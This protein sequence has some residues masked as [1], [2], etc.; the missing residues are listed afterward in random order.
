MEGWDA[1]RASAWHDHLTT[2]P[3]L[4]AFLGLVLLMGV[5]WCPRYHLHWSTMEMIHHP[6]FSAIMPRNRYSLLRPFLHLSDNTA[7][8]QNNRLHKLESFLS[9]LTPTF[10]Y[11]YFPKKMI[12]PDGSMIKFKGCLGI[13][14]YMPK[15]PIKWG[16]KAWALCE[17]DS[18][19]TWNWEVYTGH[20]EA[21]QVVNAGDHDGPNSHPP[22]SSI[23]ARGKVV[24]SLVEGLEGKGYWLFCDN[25]YTPALFQ[26][27]TENG[28]GYCGTAR[29]LAKGL[30]TGANPKVH[31]M[32]KG[33]CPKYYKKKGQMRVVCMDQKN[34]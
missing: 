10:H 7:P 15:K 1:D 11:L 2:V 24:L 22:E 30:P 6:F 14:Q 21:L 26:K 3:K 5:V 19:Y 8:N 9:L 20:E 32:K 25:F 31:K 4:K 18:G 34:G 23:C 16:I 12:S 17:S 33:G 13:A 28:F 27:L 29:P